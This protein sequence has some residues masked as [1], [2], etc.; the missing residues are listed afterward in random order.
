M[1]LNGKLHSKMAKR[2]SKQQ[3]QMETWILSESC[4]NMALVYRAAINVFTPLKEHL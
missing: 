4:R 2:L 1:A 3:L